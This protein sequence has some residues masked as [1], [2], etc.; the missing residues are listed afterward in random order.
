MNGLY[1]IVDHL[2]FVSVVIGSICN[3]SGVIL[4]KMLFLVSRC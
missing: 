4:D 3:V 2:Y 1:L